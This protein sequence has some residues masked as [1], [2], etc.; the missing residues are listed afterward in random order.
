[1]SKGLVLLKYALKTSFSSKVFATIFTENDKI[2][3][4]D[5]KS[6]LS[7]FQTCFCV[8]DIP[9]FKKEILTKRELNTNLPNIPHLKS[10]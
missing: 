10:E 8:K 7:E 3:N 6:F 4:L 1:M 2:R 9:K 5:E